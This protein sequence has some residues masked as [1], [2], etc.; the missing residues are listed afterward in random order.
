MASSQIAG[1]AEGAA[2]PSGGR[3]AVSLSDLR[4]FGFLVINRLVMRGVSCV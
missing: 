4:V 3:G 2:S 1:G